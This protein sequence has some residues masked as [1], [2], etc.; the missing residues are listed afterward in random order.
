MPDSDKFPKKQHL[1]IRGK[2]WPCASPTIL[3][4][5]SGLEFKPGD[6]ARRRSPKAIVD[7]FVL[8]WTGGE[9]DIE[10]LHRVLDKRELGV[11]FAIDREGVIWQFCDPALVDTFDAGSVNTRSFGVEVVCYGMAGTGGAV[12]QKGKD[13][14]VYQAVIRDKRRVMAGF[15]GPQHGAIKALLDTVTT[16]TP[17]I[18]R[19]LPTS[20]TDK[21]LARTMTP[22]ELAAYK[23]VI[24]HFHVS[25]N[26][27][28]PGT[29]VFDY[30]RANGYRY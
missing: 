2:E 26:K 21:L 22:E 6:G 17:T 23:G 5:D 11:E 30:L 12:P 20:G 16:A 7:L 19:V 8:H 29:E 15:Y 25:A 4:T 27:T 24:G 13:R 9:N 28:D 18:P 1:I 3:W 10:T 14:T